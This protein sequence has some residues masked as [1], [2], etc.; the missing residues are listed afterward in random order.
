MKIK[1]KQ[2]LR[3]KT[4]KVS[5]ER[6]KKIVLNVTKWRIRNKQKLVE[7]KGG[8]CVKCGY[9]RCLSSLTFH[10]R[11]PLLKEMRISGSTRSFEKL[12]KEVDKCELVCNN[13]HGEIHSG[14]IVL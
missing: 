14:L 10:H 11:D 2:P 5:D 7:Y 12:K 6:R 1:G 13:C 9:N 4:S 3:K 8:K